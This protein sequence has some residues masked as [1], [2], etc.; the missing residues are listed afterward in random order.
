MPQLS[1][2][3]DEPTMG[4]LR[5]DARREDLSLSSYARKTIQQRHNSSWPAGFFD[6]YGSIRDDS[7][8]PPAELPWESDS[9]PFD[10][11]A[12]AR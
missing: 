10:D 4:L 11:F 9:F 6:L 5:E 12:E 1:L 8:V 2:Y 3:L 7:F